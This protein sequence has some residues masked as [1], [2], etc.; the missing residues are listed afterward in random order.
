MPTNPITHQTSLK[1]RP[2]LRSTLIVVWAVV[3]IYTVMVLG[4]VLSPQFPSFQNSNIT[5]MILGIPTLL[6]LGIEYG[7]DLL[8]MF[9]FSIIGGVLIVRRSDDWFAIFTSLFLIIFGVRV[10]NLANM[11]ALT[12]NSSHVG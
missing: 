11:I 9:G 7:V 12:E 3:V 2:V 1:D 10:T 8:L 4:A 6:Q 5:Q